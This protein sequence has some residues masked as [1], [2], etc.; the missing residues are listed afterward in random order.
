MLDSFQGDYKDNFSF[1]AGLHSFLYRIIFFS[2][3]VAASTP[4]VDGLLLSI[5]RAEMH[6]K[7][8]TLEA[9]IYRFKHLEIP[10]AVTFLLPNTS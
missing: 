3:I 5:M 10:G 4:D 9:N 2:I 8:V 7:W 1:F 6:V